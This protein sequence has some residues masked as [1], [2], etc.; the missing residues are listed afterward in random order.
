[1]NTDAVILEAIRAEYPQLHVT[2]IPQSNCDFL[3]F[4]TAGHAVA[5]PIDEEH[6]R[7]KWITYQP[8]DKQFDGGSGSL[9]QSVLSGKYL[10]VWQGEQ[11]TMYVIDGRDGMTAYPQVTMQYIVSV[12][13]DTSEKLLMAAGVW[14]NEL[15]DEIW[16]FDQGYWRKNSELWDSIQQASWD[17]IILEESMKEAIVDDVVDFFG[18]RDTYQ[19]L[20]VPW[21]RGVIYYGP[22]GNGKTVS[23]KAMMHTLYQRDPQVPTVS[24]WMFS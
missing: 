13:P 16:V 2:C 14:A 3:K 15:H 8:P 11:Y 5:T 7:H 17:D 12:A 24:D 22:P 6:D 21:K 19:R 9:I 20:G 4:A 23:I 1:V 18:N 10:L